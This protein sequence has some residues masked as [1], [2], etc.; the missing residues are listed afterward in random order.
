MILPWYETVLL[1]YFIFINLF[2]VIIT[3]FDKHRAKKHKWRVREA[4][5]LLVCA[6]GGCIGMY[7]A[8]HICR[9]KTK[10]A[11]FMIGIPVIFILETAIIL[12]VY[13]LIIKH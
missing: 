1:F 4:A 5:L 13:F 11:K 3:V 2:A 6:M 10:K 7:A 8:M 9:H 12:L